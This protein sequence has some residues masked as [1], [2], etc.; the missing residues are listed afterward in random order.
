M[1][2]GRKNKKADEVVDETPTVTDSEGSDLTDAAGAET[3]ENATAEES[4]EADPVDP[5]TST[6]RDWAAFDLSADWREDG[7]FDIDE[8]DLDADE[9]QRLDFGSLIVTPPPGAELRLQVAEGT[10]TIVAILV[11]V[12]ES[13][14]ELS[15]FSAPRTPGLWSE[16]RQQ[17]IDQTNEANGTADCVEGPFGTELV[18]NVPVQLPDGRFGMQVTRT[19]VA[20]GPRWLLRGVVMGRA[21]MTGDVDNDVVGPLFDAFCDIVVRRGEHPKPVG[22]LLQ[23]QLP[24]QAQIHRLPAQG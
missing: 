13:A 14:L 18:R 15:A 10:E 19:W 17:I 23:L 24:E 21:A 7:P 22:D 8:V 9:V 16:I 4:P 20:E 6:D 1:I 12:G 11:V 2:F 3:P 5:G